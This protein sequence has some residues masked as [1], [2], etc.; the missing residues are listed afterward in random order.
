[1]KEYPYFP[2]FFNISKEK[3]V[4]IGGGKIA[5][6]RI[7]TLSRFTD[8][9]TVIAPEI[10]EEIL[11]IKNIKILKKKYEK[12]DIKDAKIVFA[13]TNDEN[14][15]DTVYCDCKELGILVNVASDRTKSDFYFPGIAQ[16]DFL[17]AGISASGKDHALAKRATEAVRECI[18]KLD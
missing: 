14:V 16:K 11:K 4:V 6:R 8:N 1:M 12:D 7:D 15:N 13:A 10:D 9:L 18:E 3:T 2:M 17:I 5:K